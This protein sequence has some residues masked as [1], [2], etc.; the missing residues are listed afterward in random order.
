MQNK[1]Y[2]IG[3]YAPSP[4]G[5]LHL[6]NLRTALLAW[7]HARLNGGEFLLRFDDLDMPRVVKGSAEQIVEDLK[8]LGLDWD[9]DIYY[10]SNNILRYEAALERLQQQGLIYPCFCSR[11]DI[12]QAISAP[13]IQL[14]IYPGTCSQLSEQQ[15]SQKLQFKNPSLRYQVEDKMIRFSDCILGDQEELLRESCGDFIVKRADGLFAY[16]FAVV[17]DDIAQGVTTVVRGSDLLDSTARQIGL[18]ESFGRQAPGYVHVPL[19]MNESGDRMAKRDGSDSIKMWKES[20]R[21]AEQLIAYLANSIGI[22]GDVSQQECS[23]AELLQ[24][25]N[26]MSLQQS[27]ITLSN[28]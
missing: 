19:L 6:G 5:R 3:R 15:L 10:Q 4:T 12:Q 16:Q 14:P 11:K 18:F 27:L 20:N 26:L 28:G 23:S 25:T 9:G 8:W 24:E 22:L 2:Y 7:L 1:P 17:V 21:S 13:H